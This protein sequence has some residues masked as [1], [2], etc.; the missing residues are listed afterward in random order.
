MNIYDFDLVGPKTINARTVDEA[1]QAANEIQY[2]VA[3]KINSVDILHKT[4]VGGVRIG[5]TN[6]IELKTAFREILENVNRSYPQAKIDGIIIQEMVHQGIEVIIG[7]IQDPQF[8]ISIMFGL[9]GIFAEIL[10]DVTF[11]ILPINDGE[12]RSMIREIKGYEVLNG[13]RNTQKVSEDMLVNLILKIS[14][15]GYELRNSLEAVDLNPIMVWGDQYRVLDGKF[16]LKNKIIVKDVSLTPNTNHIKKFFDAE[17]IALI[18]ASD[19]EGKVGNGVLDSLINHDY[20]GIV[21]PVNPKH[22]TVMGLKAYPSLAEIK[23]SIDMVVM[24]TDISFI[25]EILDDCE[26]KDVKN[27]VII[28]GGG[29]E[30]GGDNS[31]LE[32]EIRRTSKEKGIRIIG[33]NCT[34]VF[35]GK[36]QLA[37][38]FQTQERMSRPKDGPVAFMSQSGTVGIAFLEDALAFGVRHYVS[39][40]NR[41]DV[42]E[43]DL[44]EFWGN[45]QSVKVIGM[46]VEGFENGRKF[47]QVAKRI[48]QIKPIVIYKSA[49]TEHGAKASASHTGNLGGRYQVVKG[50]LSQAGLITVD[51]YDELL[52]AIK[53]IALQPE[54]KGRNVG[55][56]S[57]GAGSMIQAIDYLSEY[58]IGLPDLTQNSLMKL[59]EQYPLY[60]VKGNPIDVTGSG[61]SDDYLTGI[62]TLL[63]DPNI[64][65]VMP[66]FVFVN[67]P[68]QQDIITKMGELAGNNR[69]PILIGAFGGE[70]SKMM[71]SE[72]ES[73]G[74]PVYHSVRDW[75]SSAKA[76]S[77]RCDTPRKILS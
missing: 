23:D 30:L 53:A 21:Y 48:S 55:M 31:K 4:D 22:A 68:L 17:S 59:D 43:A 72:I 57:N 12:A 20:N 52:S 5:V 1:L 35:S 54:A 29:K 50:A 71:M 15:K 11:R 60:Y 45:D 26:K 14:K 25:P 44:L 16:I 2:P 42:D 28:S 39:Y 76:I 69:K 61:T 18:G 77:W 27:L 19:T 9:G 56:I 24:T 62:K 32:D 66:W 49:R 40:G 75:V 70:Y 36:S 74:F 33:P 67:N 8:G 38:F 65:I 13:Y 7:L 10:K 64:N 3:L 51:S 47:L 6:A 37:T 34:G 63:N 41:V 73:L 46:Y 58:Q